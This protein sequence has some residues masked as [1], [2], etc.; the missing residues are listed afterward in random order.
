MGESLVGRPGV[1]VA[2]SID[3]VLAIVDQIRAEA[4]RIDTA[5]GELVAV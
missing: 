4:D 3:D 1:G 2:S 5:L